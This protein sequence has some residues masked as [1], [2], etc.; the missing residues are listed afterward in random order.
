MN[1]CRVC[2]RDN[3]CDCIG[4]NLFQHCGRLMCQVCYT[5][6]MR[7]VHQ[8]D[9]CFK[10]TTKGGIAKFPSCPGLYDSMPLE[11]MSVDKLSEKHLEELARI[12]DLKFS[13]DAELS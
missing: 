12:A 4:N 10:L 13:T 9:F 1:Y 3:K 8:E 6:H 5:G 11:K 2:Q 7:S